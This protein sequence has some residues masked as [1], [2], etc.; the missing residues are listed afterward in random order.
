MTGLYR[1]ISR[2][3]MMK[4]GTMV[5]VSAAIAPGSISAAAEAQAEYYLPY[6]WDR[7]HATQSYRLPAGGQFKA[8]IINT[9]AM[10]ITPVSG[11]LSG[12][13]SIALPIQPYLAIRVIRI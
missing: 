4:V 5:A 1:E 2:R 3:E 6:L 7:Q 11:T 13:T 8:E 10:T 12:S 9:L